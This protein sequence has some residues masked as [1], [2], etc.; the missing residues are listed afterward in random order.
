VI[1]SIAKWM[2]IV[3][4][5]TAVGGQW[6]LLQSAAWASMF[7]KYVQHDSVSVALSKTFDGVHPCALCK[8]VD[9][10]T[11][12]SKKQDSKAPDSLKKMELFVESTFLEL[13][14]FDGLERPEF[15]GEAVLCTRSQGPPAP[16]PKGLA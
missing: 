1:R 7:A 9:K 5:L 8:V 15:G 14:V 10:A 12:D 11:S 6:A 16:P 13:T 2:L 4:L 3:A